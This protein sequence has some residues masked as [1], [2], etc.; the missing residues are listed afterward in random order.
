MRS[1]TPGGFW[2]RR[3][4]MGMAQRS[5]QAIMALRR[6]MVRRACAPKAASRLR[7]SRDAETFAAKAGPH[8]SRFA[9][10]RDAFH[11]SIHEFP[12]DSESHQ[13]TPTRQSTESSKS[14]E[15]P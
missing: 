13:Q 6:A 9:F 14:V 15:R 11:F 10:H 3:L 12:A 7:G 2:R 5:A 8:V 4:R 1:R